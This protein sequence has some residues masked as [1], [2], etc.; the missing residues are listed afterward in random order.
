MVF[1]GLLRPGILPRFQ[2][3]TER[4]ADSEDHGT[5]HDARKMGAL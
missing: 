4:A 2:R 3:E 1:P 5:R